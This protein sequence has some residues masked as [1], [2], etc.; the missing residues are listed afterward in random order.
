MLEFIFR[1]TA[2]TFKGLKKKIFKI[3][4]ALLTDPP[5]FLSLYFV[6]FNKIKNAMLFWL[7]SA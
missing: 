7:C 2:T 5:F 1:I 4:Y 3:S 6:F